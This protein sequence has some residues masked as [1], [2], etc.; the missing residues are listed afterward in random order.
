MGDVP[1]DVLRDQVAGQVP[2][3]ERVHVVTPVLVGPLDWLATAEDDAHRAAE[4]RALT[5]EWTLAGTAEVGGEAG[6]ADPVQAVEDALRTFPADAILIGGRDADPDLDVALARFGLPIE[7][8]S[9]AGRRR[10]RGYRALRSLAA[11]QHPA[12]PFVLF[13]GVNGALLLL[14]AL[15]T[16]VVLLALWLSGT[17]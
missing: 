2:P 9:P 1:P 6:E 17:I 16:L 3:P 7:R 15:L 10:S 11:G 13:V 5:A 14:G 4:V 12:T 8:L